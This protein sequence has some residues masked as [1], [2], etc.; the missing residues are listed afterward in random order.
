MVEIGLGLGLIDR[1]IQLLKF[2]QER[3]EKQFRELAQKVFTDLEVVHT[4]Y[5][6]FIESAKNALEGGTD[7]K[8][9]LD[10]FEVDRLQKEP[11]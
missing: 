1:L 9:I 3:N 11:L 2:R 6:L 7:P 8:K 10:K 4:D 5:L